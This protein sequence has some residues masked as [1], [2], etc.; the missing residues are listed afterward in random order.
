MIAPR[1]YQ[2]ACNEA[3][4][5]ATAPGQSQRVLAVMATGLGKTVTGLMLAVDLLAR[6]GIKTLW[7]AHREELIVQP[8]QS[9][10]LIAPELRP[11]IVKADRN[12]YTRDIV[13]ASIQSAAQPR[14]LEQLAT[15]G[16]GLIVVDEAHHALSPS[17]VSLLK[18]LGGFDEGG[19]I[20]VG[21]TA[22]PERSDGAG[23]D[24][25]FQRIAFQ[26]G[27]TV[28]I[29]L[30]Y[31]VPPTVEER[32]IKIDL[33]KVST[34][35]GEFSARD[36]DLALLRAGIVDEIVAAYEQHASARKSLIFTVSV[37]QA[38]TVAKAL[39]DRGHAAAAISGETDPDVRRST[40]GR[41][42]AGELKC[43]VNCMVLTEGFDD[44]SID[45]VILARPTQSKSLMIQMVGRGL[46][47]HPGKETC[48]VVDLVGASNRNTLIQA[49]VLFG[50]REDDRSKATRAAP[51]DD[52]LASPE[53]YW[54]RRLLSQA[55]GLSA[56]R[57]ILHWVPGSV[58]GEWLLDAGLFG[59]VCITPSGTG[60]VSSGRYRVHVVGV[61]APGQP[62][63]MGLSPDLVSE[64]TAQ[65]ISEDYVRR[66]NAMGVAK[67]DAAWR[68]WPA[69]DDQVRLLKKRGV[70]NADGLTRGTAADLLTQQNKKRSDPATSR[71][72][73]ALRRMGLKISPDLTKTEAARMFAMRNGARR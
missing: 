39:R 65:M 62:S 63:K 29:E 68:A 31:L 59:T 30:G 1:P 50:K 40:L 34:V 72:I 70:A 55:K 54:R 36:L 33:D 17:Y 2:L 42:R 56:P 28:A 8:A 44:P 21:L 18:R 15:R 53:E 48:T 51:E 11:G 16:F 9:L 26:M 27:I 13:F 49:A 60:A 67:E 24:E 73:T 12:E 52:P 14:R 20:V 32:K 25:V 61:R 38:E 4:L 57:S 7:L 3:I 22:T 10:K 6:R 46:R 69:T 19:P 37:D 66:V 64:E 35:R 43:I 41:L 5:E 47:L 58:E 23:L 45:C 71:Q